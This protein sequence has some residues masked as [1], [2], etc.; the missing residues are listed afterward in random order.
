MMLKFDPF[1]VLWKKSD[2]AFFFLFIPAVL[3]LMYLLPS[4][5]KTEFILYTFNP[6][7][8]SI[9]FSNYVHSNLTHLFGNLILY[10]AVMFML[11]N[12][13]TDKKRFYRVCVLI[14]ILLPFISSWAFMHYT[15]FS[16]ALQG[17][18]A[19]SSAFF[20]YLVYSVYCYLK[21]VYCSLLE[22][23]FVLLV[24]I[25]NVALMIRN[26]GVSVP[27]QVMIVGITGLLFYL[28]RRELIGLGNLIIQVVRVKMNRFKFMYYSLVYVYSFVFLFV[29]PLLVPAQIVVD[30][31]IVNAFA[32]YVGWVFGVASGYIVK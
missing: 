5:V 6:N 7:V 3:V 30:G 28:N 27:Y 15:S 23:R 10:L 11:F 31:H 25:I 2:I 20:G 16:G 14:F 1:I 18:S 32:H 29:L 9:F 8:L 22:I 24:V 4:N 12:L 13:E 26:T 17:F 21:T 19:L